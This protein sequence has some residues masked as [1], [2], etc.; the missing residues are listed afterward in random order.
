[1]NVSPQ[2]S[3][4]SCR[5]DSNLSSTTHTPLG[6]MSIS[7]SLSFTIYKMGSYYPPHAVLWR[8]YSSNTGVSPPVVG[9]VAVSGFSLKLSALHPCSTSPQVL[10]QCHAPHGHSTRWLSPRLAGH[11]VTSTAPQ[12]P[13]HPFCSLS[14][15][16][17]PWE[18]YLGLFSSGY[19]PQGSVGSYWIWAT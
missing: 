8:Q 4:Q 19:C 9:I 5:P 17:C 6:Q 11:L 13:S 15:L 2:Q 14:T 10:A 1:M 12:Y 16:C 7:L 3:G 18:C